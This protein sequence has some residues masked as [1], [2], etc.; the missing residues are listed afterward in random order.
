MEL[1]QGGLGVVAGK[2]VARQGVSLLKLVPETP[3]GIA[4]QLGIALAAGYAAR[5]FLRMSGALVDGL[6]YGA[7]GSAVEA[8]L[9]TFAPTVAT[10]LLGDDTGYEV[11]LS[12]YPTQAALPSGHDAGVAPMLMGAYASGIY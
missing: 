8:A 6:V 7:A 12:A 2:V 10:K 5:R 11:P 9:K 1:A 3:I 4:G